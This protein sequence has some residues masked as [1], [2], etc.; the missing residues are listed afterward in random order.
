MST[1]AIA[2]PI[3]LG[4]MSPMTGIVGLYGTEIN[5]AARIACDEVNSNGGIAGRSVELV[6][7]D[8]GSL[9]QTAIPAAIRLIDEYQC[10]AMI[11]NL[12]SN[13]RISVLKQVAEP[14]CIPLLN[15]SFY[16][17]SLH[18]HYFF[19][20]AALPNQQIDRMIPFMAEKCGLK[21]F[22]A[23][24]NY[25]WP[26]GSIDA[27]KQMLGKISGEVVGEEYF[28][29][30][31]K[32]SEIDSLLMHVAHSGADV[33]VPY[34]AGTD[35]IMLLT[36]FTEMGLKKRM[37]VVMGHYD[38]MMV[39]KMPAS[40]REGFYSSNTYFMSVDTVENKRYLQS[41]QQQPDV[42][43]IWPKGN[44][45]LTNF[46]EGAYLCVHA[47]AKAAN[48][49]GEIKGES[50]IRALS[51]VCVNGPQGKVTMRAKSHHAKVNNYLSRCNADGT[52]TIVSAFKGIE[53]V[54]PVRYQYQ[55]SDIAQKK[56]KWKS[57]SIS[58]DVRQILSLVD[59]LIIVTDKT[60]VI[61]EANQNACLLFDY[62]NNELIGKSI[63]NLFPLI[64]YVQNT[65]RLKK[66]VSGKETRLRMQLEDEIM[67]MRKDGAFVTLQ[68]GISKYFCDDDLMLIFNMLD[69]TKRKHEEE[70]LCRQSIYD[71]L[72]DLPN[73][74]LIHGRLNNAMKR[75][76]KDGLD[77]AVLFIDLDNFKLINDTHGH[78][79]GDILLKEV[80]E[81]LLLEV[82]PGDT[83]GRLG[84]DEFIVICEQIEAPSIISD[85][86]M[87]INVVLRQPFFIEN[88]QL[89]ISAS[90]G[91]VVSHGNE[92]TAENMLHSADLAM[93]AVKQK[94]RDSWQFFDEQL[95][96]EINQKHKVIH[97]LRQALERNEFFVCF[98]PIVS[99]TGDEIAGAELLLRWKFDGELISPDFFIPLAEKI[100]VIASI[101]R[102]VF[103]E[104]CKAEAGWRKQ[105]K[106]KAPYV[107]INMSTIQ[108]NDKDLISCFAKTLYETGADPTRILL[109][110]TE[111][112]LM[113]DVESNQRVI[114]QLSSLGLR[115]AVDDFGTGYS[116]LAQLARLS[117]SVLKIDRVFIHDMEQSK[118][119]H[120]LVRT[121]IALGHSLGLKIIAEG[122][123]TYSQMTELQKLDCDYI[124]GYLCFRPMDKNDF[125]K[126]IGSII[127]AASKI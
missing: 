50:L 68:L 22:F 1:K 4:V 41:L 124:Q 2:E 105:W 7:I 116:S 9:P 23:G 103:R 30:G 42:T 37:A 89:F 13:T 15:F 49:A 127:L 28:E 90:I 5:W 57:K 77:V 3:R 102:W 83:V 61:L 20:F 34:F 24:N 93:Y 123:E 71:T 115:I 39:S 56:E 126:K 32:E 75:S 98:Q 12:L 113:M 69:V 14:R 43:G 96:Q 51:T 87:R 18:S 99:I 73:R 64:L 67:G 88:L 66:F 11:G 118:D 78:D 65:E 62:S 76:Q 21:M 121:I 6:V 94:G 82:R 125:D 107:S 26:R 120:T 58:S 16:E 54:I 104:G 19:H 17:G 85:L 38:E 117:V 46:G 52:F 48:E 111:T 59:L 92:F 72:T 108:L 110:I 101:G 81:C 122:I 80:A 27:A 100:G 10:V 86:A 84:G 109:E 36:R 91:V 106:S 79:V 44:G 31:V 33:F 112:S 63:H 74:F 8:D 119:M 60:G 55:V 47:F 45:I 35:Q 95:Q 70:A 40:V 53:P 97:G 25:E 29:I 114:H